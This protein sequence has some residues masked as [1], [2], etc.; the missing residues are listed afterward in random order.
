MRVPPTPVPWAGR[1][2]GLGWE[3]HDRPLG[4]ALCARGVLPGEAQAG[5][6][7]AGVMGGRVGASANSAVL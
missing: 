4:R 3:D 1:Q 7:Q 2:A 6:G 5:G